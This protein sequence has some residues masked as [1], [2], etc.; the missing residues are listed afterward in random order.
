MSNNQKWTSDNRY[1]SGQGVVLIAERDP[2]TGKPM[3]FIEVG[4][5]SDLKI[6]IATT[7]LEHKESQTGQRGIDKRLTTETKAT[8]SMTMQNFNAA[9]LALSLRGSSEVLAAGTVATLAIKAYKGKIHAFEHMQ[10]SAVTVKQAA[11]SLV[12][13]VNDA[14][15]WDYKVNLDAGSLMLNPGANVSALTGGVAG[16]A[17]DLV[18]GYTFA[19]QHEVNALTEGQKE[20][21]LRFEGLN[22]ADDDAPVVIEVF[23]FSTDPLKELAMIS[24]AI[25]DFVLEGS[26]LADGTRATG[27]KYFRERTTR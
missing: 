3:G 12:E 6:S 18:V 17:I 24:D 20:R 8:L 15:P 10:I 11:V 22:T 27:S 9:N 13:Y 25:Q 7:V 16:A 26:V 1:Y 5:V 19:E 2:V 4:N 21:F 14:T 23:K